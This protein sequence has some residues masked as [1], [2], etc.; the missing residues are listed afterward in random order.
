MKNISKEEK[1][2]TKPH[3]DCLA[4][5]E[6][7]AGGPV[8]NYECLAGSFDR[9]SFKQLFKES[10]L[11]KSKEEVR[12]GMMTLQECKDQIAQKHYY[13][14]WSKL[15]PNGNLEGVPDKWIDEVAELYASS[16]TEQLQKHL[17]ECQSKELD[18]ETEIAE[19]F[20]TCSELREQLE[21]IQTTGCV[22]D[23]NIPSPPE[24]SVGE[25]KKD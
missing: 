18:L 6:K 8:K 17:A 5:A 23:T 4:Q 25:E 2:C 12:I 10:S 11:F 24:V 15:C 14:E 13:S 21:D 7:K 1:E 9:I 20:K 16:Q 19:W 3:C 22:I